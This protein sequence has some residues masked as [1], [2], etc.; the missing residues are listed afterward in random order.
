SAAH[1]P[2]IVPHQRL[3]TG[4]DRASEQTFTF[5]VVNNYFYLSLPKRHDKVIK[6]FRNRNLILPFLGYNR[7]FIAALPTICLLQD[8]DVFRLFNWTLY[9]HWKSRDLYGFLFL[10]CNPLN[11]LRI[12]SA[13]DCKANGSYL[14]PVRSK[15]PG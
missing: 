8:T 10:G 11:G 2:M 14:L 6:P 3:V 9:L 7:E 15:S 5:F 1:P 13:N 12:S 4:F